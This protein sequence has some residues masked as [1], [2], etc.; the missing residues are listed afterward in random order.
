MEGRLRA[1]L[2]VSSSR[3]RRSLELSAK[4]SAPTRT[5]SPSPA[6]HC[7][8]VLN[9]GG[10][11]ITAFRLDKMPLELSLG[12]TTWQRW[13]GDKRSWGG[14]WLARPP[15]SLRGRAPWQLSP[16]PGPIPVFISEAKWLQ[17]LPC[18]VRRPRGQIQQCKQSSA[19]A[20]DEG[21]GAS[22]IIM[23]IKH[24]ANS[25]SPSARA[26]P[27]A[28]HFH[29]QRAHRPI[30]GYFTLSVS[31]SLILTPKCPTPVETHRSLLRRPPNQ[32]WSP[33]AC[34]W[35]RGIGGPPA[36]SLW[37]RDTAPPAAEQVPRR[38]SPNPAPSSS[39]AHAWLR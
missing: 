21:S 6:R 35:A 2:A 18:P 26:V 16:L 17:C 32:P 1:G 12:P 20:Q 28:P 8:L 24:I 37:Q 10:A 36:H 14:G 29:C 39:P 23:R 27:A 38:V 33:L 5:V 34:R 11:Q 13:P 9:G 3:E 15:H 30:P 22:V 25:G 7:N 4:S 31:V 19:P